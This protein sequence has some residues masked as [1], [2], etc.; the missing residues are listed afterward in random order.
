MLPP[1]ENTP[2]DLNPSQGILL[3]PQP[4]GAPTSF[5]AKT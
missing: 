1:I 5:R 3:C 4:F 2:M